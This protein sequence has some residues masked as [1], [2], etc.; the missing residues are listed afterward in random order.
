M[1]RFLRITIALTLFF[2]VN[3]SVVDAGNP[4]VRIRN[5]SSGYA[6][7][8]VFCKRPTENYNYSCDHFPLGI[9]EERTISQPYVWI[10]QVKWRV[11]YLSGDEDC[12]AI[13]YPKMDLSSHDQSWVIHGPPCKLVRA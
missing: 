9:G 12:K 1:E 11:K 3:V 4:H 7:V 2:A 8:S 5:S 6:T 13:E 10:I